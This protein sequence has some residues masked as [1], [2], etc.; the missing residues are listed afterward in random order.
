MERIL[1]I[2]TQM[3]CSCNTSGEFTPIRFRYETPTCE[4]ITVDVL[5]VDA[6]KY[7]NMGTAYELNYICRGRENDRVKSFHLR[8]YI[9]SHRWTITKICSI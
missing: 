8:Y 5:S 6:R 4:L 7:N 1:N 2:P 3:I 9:P